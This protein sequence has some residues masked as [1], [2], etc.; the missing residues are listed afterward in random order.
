MSKPKDDRW[1]G[2][3]Q[4][5]ID[6]AGYT[7]AVLIY[8]RPGTWILIGPIGCVGEGADEMKERTGK[9]ERTMKRLIEKELREAGY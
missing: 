6:I 5:F 2:S 7:R 9:T 3:A 1:I 4:T 8:E